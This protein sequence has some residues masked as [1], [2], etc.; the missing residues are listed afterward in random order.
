MIIVWQMFRELNVFL[1]EVPEGWLQRQE[2]VTTAAIQERPVEKKPQKEGRQV[3]KS[4]PPP[5]YRNSQVSTLDSD[6]VKPVDVSTFKHTV[7]NFQAGAISRC[8]DRWKSLTSDRWILKLVNGY[9]AQF[10]SE[11]WQDRR[12]R[13]LKLDHKSQIS[14]DKTLEL[15]IIEPCDVDEEG[16]YS[17]LFTTPKN[18]GTDRVIF[19][20]SDLNE[21]IKTE[22]FKMDTVKFAIE[23]MTKNCYFA[24]IDYKHAYYSVSILEADRK[25]F[26][27]MWKGKAYQFTVMAQGLC[28]APR[29]YTKLLK[30]AFATLRGKGY[31]VLGYND[32]TI[33]MEQS[34]E[35]IMEA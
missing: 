28:T 32:N 6:N 11:P 17:T 1:Q 10:E 7:H 8:Y 25:Y 24:S 33:F 27:F 12:P 23:L 15:G 9:E 18:D 5:S 31:T 16:F 30:P 20:L 34:A 21:F 29:D 4:S 14:L 19:N 2:A 22:H 3:R 26:R 35:N 13:P